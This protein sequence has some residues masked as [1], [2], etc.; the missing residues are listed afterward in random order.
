MKFIK[1]LF[2]IESKP[3][4][5]LLPLEWLVV[6]Y[7]A[8]TLGIILFTYTRLPNPESMIWGRA[9]IMAMTLA[10]WIVY[11]LVPCRLTR[12]IRSIVQLSLLSWW[13]PDTYEINRIFPN[14]DHIFCAWEQQLFGC[15][16]SLRF[17]EACPWHVVSEL[18]SMG[19]AAYYPMIALTAFYYLFARYGEF[20]R[21]TFIVMASFLVFY[22]IFIFVP[23][24][25]PTYYFKAVG[26][27]SIAEGV[28]PAINDYFNFHKECL[29]TPGYTD[30]FFYGLVEDAKAAG[31]RPTAAFPSSHVGVAT[32][33]MLLSAHTGNRKL[34]YMQLPF[35]VFLC[36]ATVYIQA[37]YAIDAIAGLVSG[38]LIYLTLLVCTRQMAHK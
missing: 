36:M 3:K 30:G 37:H 1:Q 13:Y 24:A 18:M 26:L 17:V 7:T 10:L 6:A 32:V 23:V 12:C 16:P 33:C 8:V 29:P 5:G 31:E 4:R 38:G 22:L 14:L 27:D 15:Q 20:E 9:R 35:Y 2:E 34:V 21:A 19:Y 25:G 11:R 28:F